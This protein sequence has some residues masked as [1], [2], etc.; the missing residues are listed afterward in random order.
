[1]TSIRYHP[2]M[3]LCIFMFTTFIYSNGKWKRIRNKNNKFKHTTGGVIS[4]LTSLIN[5]LWVIKI[6]FENKKW[7]LPWCNRITLVFQ[8]YKEFYTVAR[9][10][11]VWNCFSNRYVSQGQMFFLPY[12]I[13]IS[14]THPFCVF[15]RNWHGNL[16]HIIYL[17]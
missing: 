17:W 7:R 3:V 4:Q 15:P 2:I 6:V 1:M 12:L 13:Y 14:N 5:H 9:N 11:S 8:D 16:G 10:Y